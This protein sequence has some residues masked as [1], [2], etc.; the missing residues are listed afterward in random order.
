MGRAA[1]R[2]TRA[3]GPLAALA[4]AALG[5]VLLA[6]TQP[7]LVEQVPDAAGVVWG[8]SR[9]GAEV[10]PLVPALAL[11]AGA[12]LLTLLAGPRWARW[13][14]RVLGPVAA[15]SAAVLAVLARDPA[16]TAWWW[17]AVGAAAVA[18][19]AAAA[20]CLPVLRRPPPSPSEPSGG[21]PPL[22]EHERTR[23]RNAR[24]WAQLSEG[25][26]PTAPRP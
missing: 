26:D 9:T 1:D 24:T 23:R 17:A 12:A 5:V 16:V 18:T 8:R 15:G 2:L 6:G 25:E 21:P 22:P 3:T 11:V 20:A 19:V 7:W 14:A 13:P 4:L 10:A